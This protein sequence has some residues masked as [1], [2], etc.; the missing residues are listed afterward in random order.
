MSVGI[1]S[2]VGEGE[3]YLGPAEAGTERIIFDLSQ[4]A[5]RRIYMYTKFS[6]DRDLDFYLAQLSGGGMLPKIA[7][8]PT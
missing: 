1:V 8:L 3:T 7:N 6:R 2:A 4:F 5:R